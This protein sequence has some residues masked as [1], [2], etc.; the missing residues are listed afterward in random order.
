MACQL[1]VHQHYNVSQ[2]LPS[3]FE[4]E[5][6]LLAFQRNEIVEL[7]VCVFCVRVKF[8]EGRR[9]LSTSKL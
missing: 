9:M 5:K 3:E 6:A 8:A 7:K 1:L 4:N 2:I